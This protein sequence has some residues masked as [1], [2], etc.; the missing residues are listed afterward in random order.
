MPCC[1][2]GLAFFGEALVDRGA[3][4]DARSLSESSPLA[5]EGYLIRLEIVEYLRGKAAEVSHDWC[6]GGCFGWAAS[7][8]VTTTVWLSM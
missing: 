8:A 6:E 1:H 5:R 4:I 2:V 3:S 7:P